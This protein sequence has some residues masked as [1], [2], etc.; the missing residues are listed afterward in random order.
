MIK[1][2]LL[3]FILGLICFTAGYTHQIS[4]ECKQGTDIRIVPRHIYDEIVSN[5]TL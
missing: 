4:P 1:L 2:S 3:L 5:S